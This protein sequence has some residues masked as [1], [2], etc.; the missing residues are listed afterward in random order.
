MLFQRRTLSRFYFFRV[1]TTFFSA[2]MD[3]S[4]LFSQSFFLDAWFEREYRCTG[5]SLRGGCP[6][7]G[8]TQ[9]PRQAQQQQ[10]ETR[11]VSPIFDIC[12]CG[13]LVH[14]SSA[15]LTLT[16]YKFKSCLLL[17]ISKILFCGFS[18]LGLNNF[19]NWPLFLM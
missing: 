7:S 12:L 2:P 9:P 16:L 3:D 18:V 5:P 13:F 6:Q 4:S 1:F 14:G 10:H 17:R 19:V 11:S 15:G 8:A